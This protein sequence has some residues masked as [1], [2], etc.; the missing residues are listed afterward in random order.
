[1][2][3]FRAHYGPVHGVTFAPD[4]KRLATAGEDAAIRVWDTATGSCLH[5]FTGPTAPVR[6]VAFAPN[7][8]LLAGGGWDQTVRVWDSQSGKPHR[9]F[10]RD[11]QPIHTLA[12]SPDGRHLA[13]A[14]EDH[15]LTLWSVD[16]DDDPL[17]VEPRAGLTPIGFL[18]SG[19]MLGVRGRWRQGTIR[20]QV[21]TLTDPNMAWQGPQAL[22]LSRVVL[23]PD[24]A[25]LAYTSPSPDDAE[26]FYLWLCDPAQG[27]PRHH[28]NLTEH[29]QEHP[30]V[31]AHRPDS[32]RLACGGGYLLSLWDVETGEPCGES[33]RIPSFIY[34][35]AFAPD[36]NHI[37]VGCW[38][39]SVQLWEVSEDSNLGE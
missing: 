37:A 23:A 6:A 1:M 20:S 7:G 15:S 8:Q 21:T 19:E 29:G 25:T 5:T 27:K 16:T 12:F 28:I 11:R 39:G 31:L 26:T 35:C 38:E 30:F 10:V 36:G 18:P 32:R 24:G 34:S 17:R 22:A 4:G 13:A 14:L 9:A 33:L 2:L 3:T